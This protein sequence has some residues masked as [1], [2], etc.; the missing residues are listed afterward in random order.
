MSSRKSPTR[1]IEPINQLLENTK[2]SQ[3][4]GNIEYQKPIPNDSPLN[5]WRPCEKTTVLTKNKNIQ[6]VFVG[7]DPF[8][9]RVE[10]LGQQ[11]SSLPHVAVAGRSGTAN[12]ARPIL[13][14]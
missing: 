8:S 9:D 7:V 13:K 5:F 11:D 14:Q 6:I 12:A 4:V 2:F 10:L 3:P 1:W